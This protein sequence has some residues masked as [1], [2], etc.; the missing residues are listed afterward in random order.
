MLVLRVIMTAQDSF[1][2]DVMSN[3]IKALSRTLETAAMKGAGVVGGNA[4]GQWV[5]ADGDCAM[6]TA[7]GL[8]VAGVG[9]AEWGWT[10]AR[11]YEYKFKHR[12][13]VREAKWVMA[14]QWLTMVR[15][16]VMDTSVESD[17]KVRWRGGNWCG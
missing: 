6:C 11:A 14:V 16:C 3:V 8:N 1:V 10:G 7:P 9:E 15:R 12:S 2:S 13:E 17:G 5:N 4:A